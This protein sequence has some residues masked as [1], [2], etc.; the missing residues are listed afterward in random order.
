[1]RCAGC[2]IWLQPGQRQCQRSNT[3]CRNARCWVFTLDLVCVCMRN[4]LALSPVVMVEWVDWALVA[5]STYARVPGT[6][7]RV[8]A[9]LSRLR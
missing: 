1:M 4:L 5:A 6:R 7:Q 9:S 2:V 3:A 8:P